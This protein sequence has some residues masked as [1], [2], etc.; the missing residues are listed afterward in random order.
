MWWRLTWVAPA[1]AVSRVAA[2]VSAEPGLPW[3][4]LLSITTRSRVPSC[5]RRP[6]M[7]GSF[8]S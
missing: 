8:R 2:C 7:P 3:A 1:V 6:T 5:S 4:S